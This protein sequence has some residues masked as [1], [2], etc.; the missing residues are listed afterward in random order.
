MS[1]HTSAAAVATARTHHNYL[2]AAE[3]EHMILEHMSQVRLIARRVHEQVAGLLSFEDLVSSGTLGLIAAI[4]RFDPA[5]GVKL[6]T[7]AEFKIRGAILDTLRELDWA[8]RRQRRRARAILEATGQVENRLQTT[9][10]VEDIASEMGIS[11][12]ECHDW[13]RD[14]RRLSFEPLDTVAPDSDGAMSPRQIAATGAETQP[15]R[16]IEN[17]QLREVL[18]GAI[19]RM[20]RQ[21]RI[22][23]SLMFHE[24][25]SLRE[26][27]RVMGL[28]ESRVSQIK[29]QALGRMKDLVEQNWPKKG[30]STRSTCSRQNA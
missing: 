16:Q 10:T 8:P 30:S 15:G 17:E 21:E 26:I 9:A 18:A 13:L 29:S 6:R 11:I 4:D 7:F 12:T 1:G 2:S 24:D 20:P 28:H 27:A 14:T 22:V 25:L 3:R 19:S 5:Q 23:L